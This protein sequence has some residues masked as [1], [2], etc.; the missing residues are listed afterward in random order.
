M[1]LYSKPSDGDTLKSAIHCESVSLC[2]FLSK[3]WTEGGRMS[4]IEGHQQKRGRKDKLGGWRGRR[5]W[6][7]YDKTVAALP[8]NSCAYLK[9]THENSPE[10]NACPCA[11]PSAVLSEL[12]TD[13][14]NHGR[15]CEQLWGQNVRLPEQLSQKRLVKLQQMRILNPFPSTLNALYT[16]L[17]RSLSTHEFQSN[18]YLV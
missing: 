2:S 10:E 13:T 6:K 1:C 17:I 3:A 9:R 11:F 15:H 16:M 12:K 4:F 14:P 18:F 8:F 7:V 5:G